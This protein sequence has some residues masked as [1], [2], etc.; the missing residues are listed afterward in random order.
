MEPAAHSSFGTF[1]SP[2]RA[3]RGGTGVGAS[4]HLLPGG[5]QPSVRRGFPRPEGGAEEL[6]L[7][8]QKEAK[9]S[10]Y[11]S[12]ALGKPGESQAFPAFG[13]RRFRLRRAPFRSS[14]ARRAPRGVPS[15]G[16]AAGSGASPVRRPNG[17]LGGRRNNVPVRQGF[18]RVGCPVLPPHGRPGGGMGG[19]EG[20][21]GGPRSASGWPGTRPPS[22]SLQAASQWSPG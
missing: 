18:V 12:A 9:P 11:R 13:S 8:L 22:L 21:G 10:G 15:P 1:K 7:V 20:R 3:A 14:R 19:L 6:L 4:T 17:P 5:L 16:Q 2:G